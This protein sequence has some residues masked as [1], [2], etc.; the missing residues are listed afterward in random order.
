MCMRIDRLTVPF[1]STNCYI[2]SHAGKAIA[3]DP[4][5]GSAA[6]VRDFLDT[7]HLE[8]VAALCTHAHADHVW[9]AGKLDV[10]FYVSQPDMYRLEDPVET[11]IGGVLSMDGLETK[12]GSWQPPAEV[13]TYP[14]AMY[15]TGV[16][17]APGLVVRSFAVPGH[18]QG[19]VLLLLGGPFETSSDLIAF[20]AEAGYDIDEDTPIVC[21]GDHIFA[22][23]VGRT[24]LPGGD[25][26]NMLHSLRTVTNVCD[27]NTIFLPGHGPATVLSTQL[28]TNPY[29]RQARKL[30]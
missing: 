11:T 24:D 10:P 17:F 22:G 20:G 19:Q 9:D 29:I 6:L 8:L 13:R 4:G 14:A 5:A 18:T 1:F 26:K 15:E 2:V 27:P 28:A 16:A 23:A 25:E 7:H 30:G 21:T 12:Y 3:I